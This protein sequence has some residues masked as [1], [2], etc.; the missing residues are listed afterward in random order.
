MKEWTRKR[1]ADIVMGIILQVYF[2][3]PWIH[4]HTMY[5]YL[6]QA[7]K[8]N[9]YVRVY[10]EMFLPSLKKIWGYTKPTA[11]VFLCILF[12]MLFF[13]IVEFMR[14]YHIFI[15]ERT[16]DYR[17][18]FWILFMIAFAVFND[19]FTYEDVTEYSLYPVYG[20]IYMI[21]L[22]VLVGV[23]IILDALL[24][25]WESEHAMLL[26]ELE[27]Q[28]KKAL[29]TKVQILEERYLEMLKSRKVVHDMKNHI[30]ALQVLV[31]KKEVEEADNYLDS[32]QHFMKNPQEYVA[33]GNDTID[34]LL[35]YKIQK[36]KDV[37]NLVETKISIPEKLN[38]HSFDLNVVLGNLLDNAIDASVQTKE[39]ELKIT[40]KL[41][42]GVLFLNIC[43]SCRGI[44][45]GKRGILE[46]TKS[47]KMNHG[48]GL[49]N[50]RRIVEK[51]HGDMEFLCENGSME[52]DIMIYVKD[53]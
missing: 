10:N 13:Q 29:Q 48:I 4:H 45:E 51:Y 30:L 15:N 32:M 12:L 17:G 1:K 8:R 43:N 27:E 26:T 6:Y 44:A 24:D 52:A 34:S 3:V 5:G 36:A 49:K 7:L 11:F 2:L 31:Q 19:G 16:G 9:D 46:T 40:M 18:F 28:E 53:M 33:T 38:L 14:L 35:N 21:L 20:E 47:D 41:D 50:V 39:K 42:K 25:T 23:W 22:L 37:L